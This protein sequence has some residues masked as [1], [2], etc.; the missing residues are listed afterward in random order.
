[1]D[2]FFRRFLPIF[3]RKDTKAFLAFA[4]ILGL[5]TGSFF[6]VSASNSFLSAMLSAASGRL[7][8]SGLLSAMLL[9]LLFSAF[10]VYISK[11]WLLIPIAFLKAFSF[12]YLGVGVMMAY[13]Q[14]GW[15]IRCLLMFTD[16]LIMPLLWWFWLNALT[17]PRGQMLGISALAGGV[18]VFIGSFDYFVISPFL[19]NLISF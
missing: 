15:L 3:S 18:L 1:M 7:S 12:A 19:A 16:S 11:E 10:A 17:L 4:W 14:A 8:I 2:L 13:G 9:P 5:I 6:S